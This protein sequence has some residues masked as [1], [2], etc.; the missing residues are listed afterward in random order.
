MLDPSPSLPIAFA[1]YP[2]KLDFLAHPYEATM[3]RLRA[4]IG[5]VLTPYE[6]MAYER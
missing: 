1:Y 2:I 3:I 4:D 6:G 5:Q